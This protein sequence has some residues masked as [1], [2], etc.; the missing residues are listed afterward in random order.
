[1]IPCKPLGIAACCLVICTSGFIRTEAH[2]GGTGH[3][4]AF[5]SNEARKRSAADCLMPM[6]RLAGAISHAYRGAL[7]KRSVVS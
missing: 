4:E 2:P 7:G 6:V 1:M 5:G 3:V